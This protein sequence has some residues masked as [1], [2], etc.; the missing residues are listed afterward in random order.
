MKGGKGY[1]PVPM[2]SG[3]GAA[4]KHFMRFRPLSA[5]REFEP[6]RYPIQVMLVY[7]S[8]SGTIQNPHSL[9][10]MSKEKLLEPEVRLEPLDCCGPMAER[11]TLH[12]TTSSK[13][14]DKGAC[15]RVA[16]SSYASASA[17]HWLD[18]GTV[19]NHVGA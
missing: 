14:R 19:E 3:T 17:G 11:I 18:V 13:R 9:S 16:N 10:K 5:T 8:R 2:G 7:S 6:A 1:L 4:I 15:S 12:A